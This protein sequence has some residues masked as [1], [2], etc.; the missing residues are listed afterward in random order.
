MYDGKSSVQ[1]PAFCTQIWDPSLSPATLCLITVIH[2]YRSNK[3]LFT[4]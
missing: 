4:K 2:L 1:F 3:N